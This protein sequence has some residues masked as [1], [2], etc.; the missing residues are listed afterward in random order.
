MQLGCHIQTWGAVRAR[1]SGSQ[2]LKELFLESKAPQAR[3][4]REAELLGYEGI[5]L[6]DG[7]LLA[8]LE[9]AGTIA[10]R[11]LDVAGVYSS[12]QFVYDD[13][14]KDELHKL[15][16]VCSAATRAPTRNLILG[17]GAVRSTGVSDGDVM[18]L[19][20]R[21]DEAAAVAADHG[22]A[23]HFHPH[24]AAGEYSADRLSR[25][26]E[27]STIG[28]CPDLAVLGKAGIDPVDFIKTYRER[29]TYVHVKDYRSGEDIEV[30][31]GELDLAAVASHLVETKHPGWVVI[32]LDATV[33]EPMHAHRYML[34]ALRHAL[35]DARAGGRDGA[36]EAR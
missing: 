33:S 30:G 4:V 27:T 1:A 29:I 31:L 20:A 14:W 5:E 21:L 36:E 9:A 23:A 24:P 7:D 3:C 34:N 12:Y 13:L 16:R 22:L 11:R 2:S 8:W 25:I 35:R 19:A 17:G 18:T 10:T 6:F 28:I 26:I 32:E 15:R